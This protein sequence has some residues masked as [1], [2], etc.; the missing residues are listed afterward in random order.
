MF[1][2]S[3][4]SFM[5]SIL[6]KIL[7]GEITAEEGKIRFLTGFREEV[8]GRRPAAKTVAKYVS[9]GV[10]YLSDPA[11]PEMNV[12]AVEKRV[13][14]EI[15][16]FPFTGIIDLL[17]KQNGDFIIVDH[18]SRD[19]K[20]RSKRKKPT[21]N[22]EELDRMLRQLYLYA[23]GV[24]QEYGVL[25]KKLCFNCFRTGAFIEEPFD[26]KAYEDTLRWAEDSIKEIIDVEEF[27]PNV[28]F[29]SCLWLCGYHEDC[30]Y[31]EMR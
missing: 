30:C 27:R 17:G 9:D 22:D 7:R 2:A 28:E 21:K 29:F 5:H 8:R 18:K 13:A 3:Y 4:G 11:F 24:E 31:W 12:V 1:Y 19:L 25:P 14:F 16:G 15:S 20:P 26:E 23:R 10:R 6:E